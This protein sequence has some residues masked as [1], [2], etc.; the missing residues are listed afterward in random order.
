MS[1]A[2]GRG[3]TEGADGEGADP[4]PRLRA[5]PIQGRVS[6]GPESF[7]VTK[8]CRRFAEFVDACRR[9][10]YVGLCHGR[11]G[12]GKTLSARYYCGWDLVGAAIEDK[13]L[14]VPEAGRFSGRAVF[15]TPEVVNAPQKI[16][17]ELGGL[18]VGYNN[19]VMRALDAPVQKNPHFRPELVKRGISAG[20][21]EAIVVD[22]AN[23]LKYPSLEQL[24]DIHDRTGAALILVGMP[25]LERH[26]GRYLQLYSRIGFVHEY[27]PVSAEELRFVLERRWRELGLSFSPEDFTDAEAMTAIVRITAGNFRLLHRLFAQIERILE[28]NGLHTVSKE[29]VETAREGMVLGT[30][31]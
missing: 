25:G 28:I 29:V 1:D 7:I 30:A 14:P 23:R 10:R 16:S 26:L 5:L 24:R 3:R 11:P 15:Y 6:G 21:V 13:G 4:A 8:E 9:Y 2:P 17:R 31:G 20:Y 19:L 12:V 18:L 27:R 22:E